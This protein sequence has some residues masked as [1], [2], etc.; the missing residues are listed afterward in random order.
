MGRPSDLIGCGAAKSKISSAAR[1][2]K[3]LLKLL[4]PDRAAQ[5]ALLSS[6]ECARFCMSDKKLQTK[7]SSLETFKTK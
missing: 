6:E 4:P 1:A 3:R 7:S 5:H 2:K